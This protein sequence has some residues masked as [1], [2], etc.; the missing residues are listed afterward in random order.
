M[1]RSSRR[2]AG[3]SGAGS[4]DHRMSLR[5]RRALGDIS[6]R[7]DAQGAA[8]CKPRAAKRAVSDAVCF[9]HCFQRYTLMLMLHPLP[10]PF[11]LIN[12][13]HKDLL[14]KL[15]AMQ[16]VD[17]HVVHQLRVSQVSKLQLAL[18][19]ELKQ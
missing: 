5:P 14:L 6:N 17:Q 3:S 7:S 9:L 11:A 4:S 12:R 2:S 10:S 13:G 16:G 19:G 15:H 18:E 8:D 1:P